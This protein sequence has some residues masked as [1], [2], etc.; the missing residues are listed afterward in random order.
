MTVPRVASLSVQ[1][2]R[3]VDDAFPG[4]VA[5]VLIDANGK[6]HAFTEKVPMVSAADLQ[7]DSSYP[8]PGHIDCI[9]ESIWVDAAGRR[10][11]R[12]ST[13]QPWGIASVSGETVFKVLDA[14]I[15]HEN[16]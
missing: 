6:Q 16:Q 11:A 3:H 8:Q 10:L 5:C 1:I 12:V 9:V 7:A 4:W 13:E 14:Q 15:I 2:E